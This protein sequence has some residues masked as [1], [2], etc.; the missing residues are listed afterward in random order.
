MCKAN[1]KARKIMNYEKNKKYFAGNDKHFYI[2]VILMAIGAVLFALTFIDFYLLPYQSFTALFFAGVGACVAFIPR[3]LRTSES[4]LDAIVEAKTKKYAEETVEEAGLER[5]LSRRIK[6]RTLGAYIF[7]GENI[8]ARRG[9][10]D[11]KYRTNLYTATALVFTGYGIYAAQKTFSFTEE[12]ESET[13]VQLIYEDLDGVSMLEEEMALANGGKVKTCFLVFSCGGKEELRVP[14][15]GDYAT[16]SLCED[17]NHEI[18]E[19]K[20]KK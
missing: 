18:A 8:T 17:I 14:A 12:F 16:Q 3:A 20:R 7:E 5:M 6:P 15:K 11:R 4:E 10:D 13:D 9:K 2:G 1:L 19:A